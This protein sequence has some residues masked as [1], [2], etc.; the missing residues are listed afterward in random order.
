MSLAHEIIVLSSL[1]KGEI[2]LQEEKIK[3]MQIA[4]V[5]ATLFV[6]TLCTNTE[7]LFSF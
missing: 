3:Y 7:P 1:K 4:T 6:E 5:N 2:F